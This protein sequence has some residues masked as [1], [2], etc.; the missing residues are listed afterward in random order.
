MP[1]NARLVPLRGIAVLGP[2]ALALPAQVPPRLVELHRMLPTSA[3]VRQAALGDVDGDG[4]RDIVLIGGTRNSVWRSAGGGR[5][6]VVSNALP[7]GPAIVDSTVLADLDGDGDL[8]LAAAIPATCNSNGPGCSGGSEAVLW[9]DGT[10]HFVAPGPV[11]PADPQAIARAVAAGDIDGDG[12][13]D[14]VFGCAPH[15]WSVQNYPFPPTFTVERG[16]NLLFLNNGSGGFNAANSRLGTD[17]DT[18]N[19][20]LLVDFDGDGDLDLFAANAATP[21]VA[22]SAQDAYYRND[23][24]GNFTRNAAALPADNDDAQGA[25][26]LDI[27][28]D[29]DRDVLL[30]TAQ[31]LRLLRNNGAGVFADASSNVT[32][33]AGT[34]DQIF[35]GDFDGNGDVDI[36][37]RSG[38][39]IRQLR[40]DGTGTFAHLPAA[41]R[42]GDGG[43]VLGTDFDADGDFDV[44]QLLGDYWDHTL[45]L[46]DGAGAWT[47]VPAEMPPNLTNQFA[48]VAVDIDN[49]GDLDVVACAELAA[50]AV[51]R[52][53]GS[54][55]FALAPYGDFT[56]DAD[57]S[58]GLAAGDLDGDGFVDVVV[59]NALLLGS[60]PSRIYHN[61][62]A[63]RL[64]RVPTPPADALCV[65]LGDLDRDGDLD[66]YFG[67][68]GVDVVLRNMGNMTFVPIVGA[69]TDNLPT[70]SVALGD[71][72]FDGDL[73]AVLV[74]WSG[75]PQR[76]LL[77]N[78][79]GVFTALPGALPNHLDDSQ[80]VLLADIDR[81]ADLDIIVANDGGATPQQNRCY[82]NNGFGVFS[83][84]GVDLPP[85]NGRTISLTAADFDGDGDL[86]L[87]ETQFVS[88][89]PTRLL[90]NDGL[91]HFTVVGNGLPEVRAVAHE[92]AAADFDRDG[93]LDAFLVAQG[94]PN[95]YWNL[96]H[97][98]AWRD[99]PRIG[100]PLTIDLF[101][102]PGE[103]Y[104]FAASPTRLELPV[105]PYGMLQIDVGN[106]LVFEFGVLG[107]QGRT[108]RTYQVPAIPAFVGANVY[109][110]ALTGVAPVL[111][112][113]EITTLRAN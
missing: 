90:E 21:S 101:G 53:D 93:D 113:L 78:G 15:V 61:D 23:G 2:F 92:F 27:D 30:R 18:T 68:I 13:V 12:D 87:I 97:Q 51:Y 9:N 47:R 6:E 10:G 11:L 80:H 66:I 85:G 67:C 109:W 94:P 37:L 63:G 62:G 54:G 41:D 60:A 98:L 40:N 25:L 24:L 42:T 59:A 88:P 57:A 56:T 4:A 38:A 65:A 58:E 8:D 49:D 5:F 72:D 32:A 86:D 103:P 110:Q 76:V 99:L 19:A 48:P 50:N 7:S 104:A 105:P 45:W 75:T 70:K 74:G 31:G 17:R 34:I 64:D 79:N 102:T 100:R 106:V 1:S 55:R 91:G 3:V 112:N 14:L 29:G 36:G 22:G 46:G 82:R 81:D 111:G 95:M 39:T 26:A 20:V 33:P 73:D 69:V 107:A 52:N 35:A 108:D 28:N 84:S 96:R 43:I 83:E 44:A 89:V 77:N 16:E 71:V